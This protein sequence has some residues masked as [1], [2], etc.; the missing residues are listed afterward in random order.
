MER[1]SVVLPANCFAQ[2]VKIGLSVFA[3]SFLFQTISNIYLSSI[4]PATYFKMCSGLVNFISPSLPSRLFSAF[5]ISC[6]ASLFS[7]ATYFTPFAI[8][9]S[10]NWINNRSTEEQSSNL[11]KTAR[12][13]HITGSIL[14]LATQLF[15]LVSQYPHHEIESTCA[16]NKPLQIVETSHITEISSPTILAVGLASATTALILYKWAK[17]YH[18]KTKDA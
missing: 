3:P 11:N 8:I 4:D 14:A 2:P 6:K 5:T 10:Y 17:M 7:V 15:V 12:L 13:S 1:S 9:A 18:P 16:Y